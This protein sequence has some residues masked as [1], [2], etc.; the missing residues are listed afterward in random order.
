VGI[1]VRHRL[2]QPV[3]ASGVRGHRGDHAQRVDIQV[4]AGCD[5]S[6]DL[7]ILEGAERSVPVAVGHEITVNLVHQEHDAAFAANLTQRGHVLR[8]SAIADRDM[9][10][11]VEPDLHILQS[12]I[13]S[14]PGSTMH[15]AYWSPT[16]P[17]R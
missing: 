10:P 11:A 17:T 3:F 16:C 2:L 12:S 9:L 14:F 5:D 1:G 6:D 13:E 8:P 4:V 7:T 15:S